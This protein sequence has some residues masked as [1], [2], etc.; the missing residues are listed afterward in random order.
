MQKAQR[1]QGGEK[2]VA[3]EPDEQIK[4]L[5]SQY[6]DAIANQKWQNHLDEA[7]YQ[8]LQEVPSILN[9]LPDQ[10]QETWRDR[11]PPVKRSRGQRYFDPGSLGEY[12]IMAQGGT[13]EVRGKEPPFAEGGQWW[14]EKADQQAQRDEAQKE[15]E[16]E[17]ADNAALRSQPASWKPDSYKTVGVN[18]NGKEVEIP[19]WGGQTV[20]EAEEAARMRLEWNLDPFVDDSV[21][22][23]VQNDAHQGPDDASALGHQ[24]GTSNI[25]GMQTTANNPG[26]KLFIGKI[27]G[28]RPKLLV[29]HPAKPRL[30]NAAQLDESVRTPLGIQ[31]DSSKIR[32]TQ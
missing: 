26:M 2:D 8:R 20:D 29:P 1:L 5:I 31:R 9:K 24:K 10:Y 6:D 32:N 15:L 14:W 18:I 3:L 30:P 22:E 19:Q 4:A 13:N 28:T 25:M 7:M 21:L 16:S 12:P 17:M 11:E 23:K 27:K